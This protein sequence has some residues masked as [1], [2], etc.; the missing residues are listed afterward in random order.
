MEY[1]NADDFLAHA[2]A[3]F[4]LPTDSIRSIKVKDLEEFRKR[5]SI[6]QDNIQATNEITNPLF[7]DYGSNGIPRCAAMWIES[8]K[9]LFY[10]F[11][12]D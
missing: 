2:I 4:R 9:T 8:N 5:V 7:E 12:K 11:Q 3:H 6:N 10:F 1:E